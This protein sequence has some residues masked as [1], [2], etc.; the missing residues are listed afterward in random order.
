MAVTLDDGFLYVKGS[1]S[2]D[3]VTATHGNS[4]APL[5]DPLIVDNGDGSQTLNFNLVLGGF[6]DN[7]IGFKTVPPLALG[8][9]PA[10]ATV[11]LGSDDRLQPMPA[12]AVERHS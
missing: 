6:S 7:T 3:I 10:T 9:Y 4:N 11:T 5:A 1:A 12:T 2:L 8:D